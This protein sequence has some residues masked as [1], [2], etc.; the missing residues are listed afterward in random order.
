MIK[1]I[2][3]WTIREGENPRAKVERMAEVKARLSA[4]PEEI[5][6]IESMEVFFNSPLAAPNNFDVLLSATFRTWADLEAYQKHPA[7]VQV[8]EYIK[9][10]R[11][12]RAVVD[13]EY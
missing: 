4:L 2:V 5:S 11:H 7:H 12:Q 13:Y 9:N 3:M 6:E 1:H 8:A 10:I